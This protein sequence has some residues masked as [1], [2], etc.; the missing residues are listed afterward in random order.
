MERPCFLRSGQQVGKEGLLTP[1][2]ARAPPPL[3]GIWQPVLRAAAVFCFPEAAL[4][5][6][7]QGRSSGR[8]A[9]EAQRGR[10]GP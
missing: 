10:A 9:S 6:R 5:L 7:P 1:S 3:P 4:L 8:R 2:R